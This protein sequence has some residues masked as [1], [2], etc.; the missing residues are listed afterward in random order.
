[1]HDPL[2][3][4]RP[5]KKVK[6]E[7][8]KKR[9]P[10]K[11]SPT[12]LHNAGLYYLGRY[13]ASSGHFRNVMMRKITK[14]CMAHPDQNREQCIKMLD[15]VIQ[16]FCD[17]GLL[18]DTAYVSGRIKSMRRQGRSVRYIQNKLAEKSVPR[19]VIAEHLEPYISDENEREAAIIF[20]RKKR[21]YD[22]DLSDSIIYKRVMGQFARAGYSYSIA[23]EVIR[24]Y[25]NSED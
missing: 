18:D 19:D 15:T 2:E 23:K 25:S 1:M 12:Y 10:K 9:V 5:K 22:K 16:T 6:H 14:S 13:A 21:V 7:R 24:E 20:A 11:I 8:P 3:N 4:D 17:T